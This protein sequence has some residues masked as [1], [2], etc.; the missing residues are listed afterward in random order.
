M[1]CIPVS[2]TPEPAT[3][4]PETF[5]P[6]P[7]EVCAFEASRTDLAKNLCID[8]LLITLVETTPVDWPDAC[9]GLAGQ[10]EACAQVVTPGFRVRMEAGGVEYEY[11]TN[12]NASLFRRVL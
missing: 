7:A 12:Q 3:H 1:A 8:P 10:D 2:Q 6:L 4:T 9:L 11:H 5:N